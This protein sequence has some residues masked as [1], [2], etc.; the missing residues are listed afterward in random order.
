M[1]LQLYC[2]E[3]KCAV[4]EATNKGATPLT[5]LCLATSHPCSLGEVSNCLNVYF[6]FFNFILFYFILFYFILFYF[7][8]ILFYFILFYFIL[9]YFILFYFILFY[10]ILFYFLLFNIH[11]YSLHSTLKYLIYTSTMNHLYNPEAPL[12]LPFYPFPYKINSGL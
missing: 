2:G 6:I 7:F 10:F 5:N 1:L 9:F 8:C 11:L 12:R 4:I 3:V